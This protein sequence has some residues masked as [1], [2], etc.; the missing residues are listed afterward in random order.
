V[1]D[2]AEDKPYT[3]NITSRM[4]QK[5]HELSRATQKGHDSDKWQDCAACKRRMKGMSVWVDG[6]PVK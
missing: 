5:D 4:A 6:K 2:V 3:R 1:A